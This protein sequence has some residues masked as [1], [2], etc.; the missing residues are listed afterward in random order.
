MQVGLLF[1]IYLDYAADTPVSE[2]V[3]A[4]FCELCRQ[5]TANPNAAHPMAQEEHRLLEAQ[6]L[7]L[8]RALRVRPEELVYTSGATEANNLA[9]FGTAERYAQNGRHIIGTMLEHASVLGPLEQLRERGYEVDYVRHTPDGAVDYDHLASLLRADTILVT[10]C[11]VDSELGV[12][13][14]IGR[15]AEL[16]KA[17]PN[18]RLHTD[19][20]QALGKIPFS[21][22]GADLVTVAPHKFY[23][24]AGTGLLLV[25]G[26]TA[27]RPQ[28]LGG[29]S[30]SPYRAGTPSAALAGACA[31][32]V[33]EALEQLDA[34]C[35]AVRALNRLLRDRLD[36]IPGVRLNSPAAA[37][38]YILNFSIPGIKPQAAIAALGA[39]GF[40]IASK[41]ACCAPESPSRPVNALYHDRKR[42]M[43]S[44]RVS[45]S[46]LTGERELLA[47]VQSV[48]ALLTEHK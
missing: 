30:F 15:I 36:A 24:L 2:R 25:R 34:R 13:Q 38:P 21:P 32:A 44:L 29:A 16:L 48:Q 17:Y 19:A 41:S 9:I 35:E 23:G 28:L 4:V 5:H 7:R 33:E 31:E 42:A 39:R 3:L 18:C 12:V 40:C 46:H 14:D 27:L 26:E 22:E 10:A 8:A 6:S 1:M 47:F 20:S 11:L 45:L 43:H 37:S